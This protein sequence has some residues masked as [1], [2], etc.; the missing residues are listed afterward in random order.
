MEVV[1]LRIVQPPV[2]VIEAPPVVGVVLSEPS[3]AIVATSSSVKASVRVCVSVVA[4]TSLISLEI[5]SF[6]V[7]ARIIVHKAAVVVLTLVPGGASA[8]AAPSTEALV[9]VGTINGAPLASSP[10]Q[11]SLFIPL[12]VVVVM[13]P[14]LPVEV[15]VK[16]SACIVIRILFS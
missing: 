3:T 6:E 9:V 7:S 2:V 5:P 14:A 16:L 4:T 8:H 11:R 15:V 10:H 1:T 13:A 12:E